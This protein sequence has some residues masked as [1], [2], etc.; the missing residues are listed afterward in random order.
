M[1]STIPAGYVPDARGRL[2]PASM[3]K[4]IDRLRDQ[5]I[6]ALIEDAR[7]LHSHLAEFKARAFADIAAFVETS[8]E[9]YG[10]RVGGNKG[11]ISLVTFDGRYKVVRQIAEY[12]QFDERLQAARELIDACILEWTQGSR[13]EIKVLISEAFQVDKEGKVS[14]ARILALRRR[15]IEHPKWKLAMQ[16]IADSVRVTDSRP[17][18]RL[19]ERSAETGDY[20]PI[21]LDLAGV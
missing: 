10:L 7:L 16:A 19:Y 6:H 1:H 8:H 12:I 5:T 2:V 4:P 18:V 14:T 17:Y 21:S 15:S 13:D 9:A 3:V 20:Q 11:N